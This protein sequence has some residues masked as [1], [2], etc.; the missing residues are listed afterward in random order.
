MLKY[1]KTKKLLARAHLGKLSYVLML[2]AMYRQ[3]YKAKLE[4]SDEYYALKRIKM[5]NEKEGVGI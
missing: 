5:D 4:G 1:S 2:T 3:V